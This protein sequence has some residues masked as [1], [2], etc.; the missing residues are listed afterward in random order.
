MTAVGKA[1]VPSNTSS[2][3]SYNDSVAPSQ[4]YPLFY[5]PPNPSP[6]PSMNPHE[7]RTVSLPV[8]IWNRVFIPSGSPEQGDIFADAYRLQVSTDPTFTSISWAVDTENTSATPTIDNPFTPLAETDYFWRVRP[9]IGGGE[10]GEWSQIWK[11]RFDPAMGLPP[12]SDPVLIRPSD[13]FEFAESTPLLE[14]FPISGATGYEVQISDDDTFS[15]VNDSASVSNP[16]YAPSNSLAQRSL[17]DVDFGIYYWRVRGLPDGVWSETRRFQIAAQSQWQFS[18]TLGDLANRLQIGSDP[19]GDTDTSDYD[20][21]NLHVAQA[22]DSWYFG[23]ATP[24]SPENMSRMRFILILII[25]Q[26]L[27]E[28]LTQKDIRSALFQVTNPNTLFMYF[29]ML[30]HFLLIKSTFI[31][32]QA[33]H[34]TL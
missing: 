20:V 18:R 28:P 1:G 26:V 25:S 17:V 19:I 24:A 21:S 3:R 32:G 2:Y 14:W 10:T 7:D 33:P 22:S 29:R 5:Y 23:F 9:L 4:V 27:V 11:A 30:A 8:F 31:V 13:G 6:N 16:V 15:T 34:G 12:E